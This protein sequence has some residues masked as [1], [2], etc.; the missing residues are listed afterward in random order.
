MFS[1]MLL[2]M[3]KF[4]L[5]NSWKML[6]CVF[7]SHCNCPLLDAWKLVFLP[8]SILF[9]AGVFVSYQQTDFI[10]HVSISR[11]EIVGPHCNPI[12][13][14]FNQKKVHAI[15]YCSCTNLHV[16]TMCK[17]SFFFPNP[18]RHLFSFI[19]LIKFKLIEIG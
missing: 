7:M 19:F 3:T 6:H 16:L 17:D 14:F 9:S 5:C 11:T 12:S 8:L 10:L 1:F 2:L 18:C 15:L 4:H 13:I